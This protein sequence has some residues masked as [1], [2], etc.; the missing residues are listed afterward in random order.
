MKNH[1]YVYNVKGLIGQIMTFRKAEKLKMLKIGHN[2]F[3]FI[4]VDLV[5]R[6]FIF[7]RSFNLFQIE[8]TYIHAY[9][10]R[11]ILEGVAE[12]SQIFLRDTHV[13]P[14]LVG[15]EEHCSRDRW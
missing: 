5:Q 4:A 12:A 13:L 11:F 14:K 2:C 8:H 9:H 1:I 6:T 3:N 10:S 15:Y 7:K